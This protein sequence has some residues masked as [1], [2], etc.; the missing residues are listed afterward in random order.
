MRKPNMPFGCGTSP[1]GLEE[2]LKSIG[3]KPSG[4]LL[5]FD[6][7]Y[8]FDCDAD[9]EVY[10][11]NEVIKCRYCKKKIDMVWEGWLKK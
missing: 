3:K 2:A 9:V 5:G 6:M 7:I 4:R 10:I 1:N 8:C 11:E